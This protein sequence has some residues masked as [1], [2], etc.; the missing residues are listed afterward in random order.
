MIT[1]QQLRMA[2]AA[3]NISQSVVAEAIGL[4]PMAISDIENE[5][6]KNPKASTLSALQGFYENCGLEF[7]EAGGVRPNNAEIKIYKGDEGFRNFYNDIYSTSKDGS[8]DIAIQNGLPDYLIKHLGSDYY[9]MHSKRMVKISP[10]VRV[11]IKEGDKSLIGSNFATYKTVP[12]EHFNDQTI[13][14]YGD[15]TGFITF[16]DEVEVLVLDNPEITRS[17]RVSFDVIWENAKDIH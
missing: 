2:R 14:I 15:Q 11:L 7:T 1:V 6:T 10:N 17:L 8:G 9:D 5:K 12:A 3:L 16:G 4:N 13:Y